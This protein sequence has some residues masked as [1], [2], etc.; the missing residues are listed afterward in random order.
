MTS[1][2]Y[3]QKWQQIPAGVKR[4]LLKSI[5]LFILWK[6][7]YLLL[8]FPGRI[9]DSPLTTGTGVLTASGLNWF[10]HSNNYRSKSEA[11]FIKDDGYEGKLVLEQSVYY[12][13]KKLVS[14]Y[15]ACN[16][17]ELYVL[18]AG[19][20]ICMPASIKRKLIFIGSGVVLIFIVNIFRCIGVSYIIQYYPQ[21]A[22]FVHH[23]L[24]VFVVYALI[25][26]MWLI[27]VRKIKT[28]ANAGE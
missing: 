9:L 19:F 25:I 4:F 15:D 7:I 22:D 10:T 27:F 18:F 11:G 16:A 23:Y 6:V 5:L 1:G 8:L 20:I 14:I 17:L 21:N 13:Q 2:A 26:A 28:E 3:L 24:F 12:N